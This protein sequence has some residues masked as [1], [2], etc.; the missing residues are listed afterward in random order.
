MKKK[1]ITFLCAFSLAAGVLPDADRTRNRPH[2]RPV[3]LMRRYRKD[4]R[5]VQKM[6]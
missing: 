6:R 1:I 4:H 3:F 5:K 2:R